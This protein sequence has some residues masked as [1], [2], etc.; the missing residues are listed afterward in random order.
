MID[1][2]TVAT[3]NGPRLSDEF[4]SMRTTLGPADRDCLDRFAARVE[5]DGR[6][7]IN[8]RVDVLLELIAASKYLNMYEWAQE[9]ARWSPKSAE[10]ILQERLGPYH[11]P[12][13]SFEAAFKDGKQFRYGSLNIGGA[14]ATGYGDFC[15]IVDDELPSVNMPVVYFRGDSLKSYVE[16]GATVDLVAVQ[17]DAAPHSHRHHLAA[18]KHGSDVAHIPEEQWPR[19]VCSE[20]E[21]IEAIFV[22]NLTSQAI[23]RVR[24]LKSDHDRY[25]ELAFVDFSKKLKPEERIATNGFARLY[26]ELKDRGIELEVVND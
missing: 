12:R 17:R 22:G 2:F 6:I 4:Q 7:A 10:E 16:P 1:L 8:M 15:A 20:D 14:G 13:I 11:Q 26:G 25:F 24:M 5:S 21:Y 3:S 18:L 19:R 9:R 23:E